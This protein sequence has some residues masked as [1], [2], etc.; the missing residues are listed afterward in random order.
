MKQKSVHKTGNTIGFKGRSTTFSDM[1][2]QLQSAAS[3]A[4]ETR[5]GVNPRQI[6]LGVSVES[7]DLIFTDSSPQQTGR[8]TDLA[9]SGNGLFVL[10]G[11]EQEYY[12]R[13]GAFS[14]SSIPVSICDSIASPSLSQNDV[15]QPCEKSIANPYQRTNHHNGNAHDTGIGDK[16]L[17]RRPGDLLHLRNDFIQ[18]LLGMK[19]LLRC[20]FL[21]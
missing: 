2:S 21:V 14:S 6:G 1:L 7:I 17:L 19:P 3:S 16:L 5:G 11:G 20:C 10:R 13:N 4:T 9:L 15:E 12:T 18:E 8:N